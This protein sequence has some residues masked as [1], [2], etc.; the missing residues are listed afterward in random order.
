MELDQKDK[1]ILQILKENANLTTS[2]IAKKTAIPITTVHNRIKKLNKEKVIKNYTLNLDFEKIGKPLK[3][4]IL[5][6]INQ[7]KISQSEIGKQIREIDGVESVD[8]VTGSTDIIVQIR[9][10]DMHSLNELITE[11]I[12]KLSGIDKTQTLMVLEE[13]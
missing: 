1:K 9:I 13:I 8:I 4:F 10:K 3:A 5:V 12:R 7:S 2:Q 11:K 6:T